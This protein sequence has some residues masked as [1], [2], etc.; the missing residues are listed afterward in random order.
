[1]NNL[2]VQYKYKGRDQKRAVNNCVGEDI[3][4]CTKK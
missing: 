4:E 1:M 2:L 3:Y